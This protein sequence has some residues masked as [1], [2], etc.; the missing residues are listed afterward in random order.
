MTWSIWNSYI[1]V[2]VVMHQW[3]SEIDERCGCCTEPQ[4]ESIQHLFLQGEVAEMVWNLFCNAVSIV[5]HR[6]NLVQSVRLWRK[7]NG[8]HKFMTVFYVVLLF[9][10]QF[11]WKRR[12]TILHNGRYKD[13]NITWDTTNSIISLSNSDFTWSCMEKIGLKLFIFCIVMEIHTS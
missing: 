6:L 1:P 9:M 4:V 12:N 13:R 5:E 8:D 7:G 2:A 11:L 10:F 3:N